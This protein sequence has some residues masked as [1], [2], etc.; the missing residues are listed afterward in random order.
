MAT[1]INKLLRKKT[2]PEP[3]DLH[4]RRFHFD[5]RQMPEMAS[6]AS[7]MA[8]QS[9][10]DDE[11]YSVLK[12][13]KADRGLTSSVKIKTYRVKEAELAILTF[14]DPVASPEVKYGIC[15]FRTDEL[16]KHARLNEYYSPY[17]V[18]AKIQDIWAIGEIKCIAKQY[19][20]C[21]TTFYQTMDSPDLIQFVD[22]VMKKENLSMDE[23]ETDK[24]E[25]EIHLNRRKQ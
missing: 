20:Y 8:V 5:F 2:V 4:A 19:D 13:H 12:S 25:I 21:T 1:L 10:T 9:M 24:D 3:V 11:I 18:L 22:W 14:P 17:Y 23:E 15:F 16:D 7:I 6:L